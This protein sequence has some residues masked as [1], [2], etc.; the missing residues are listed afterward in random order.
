[1]LSREKK[2]EVSCFCADGNIER[3]SAPEMEQE[4]LDY[5]KGAHAGYYDCL[6]GVLRVVLGNLFLAEAFEVDSTALPDRDTC[7]ERKENNMALQEPQTA[8]L[9]NIILFFQLV[10]SFNSIHWPTVKGMPW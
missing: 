3:I 4:Q 5:T 7:W 6:N 10:C 1:M 2:A 9:M 8:F